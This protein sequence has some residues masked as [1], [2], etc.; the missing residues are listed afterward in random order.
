MI[1]AE[2]DEDA[3]SLDEKLLAAFLDGSPAAGAQT[4]ASSPRDWPSRRCG[5][6]A[7]EPHE[8]CPDGAT[9][10]GRTRRFAQQG[11]ILKQASH[12]TR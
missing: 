10:I 2:L 5:K 4:V 7:L 3:D 8:P 1:S 12:V 6:E 9:A 11:H